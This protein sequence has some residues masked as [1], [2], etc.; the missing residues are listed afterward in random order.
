MDLKHFR[1]V[2]AVAHEKNITKAAEK[3]FIS[4]SSLSYTLS[5]VEKEIGMPLFLRS[6]TGMELT[7]AGEEYYAAAKKIIQI[8]DDL[9]KNLRGK[10]D[11]VRIN[12]AASSVWGTQLFSELIPKFRKQHPGVTFNL[13]QV[14]LFYMEEE[15]KDD[16]LD[17]AFISLSPFEK[18]S[19]NMML[20]RNEA[21]LFAVPCSHPYVKKNPGN[22][23]STKD[24]IE[25]FSQDTF[26]LS[27][28][29]SANRIVAEHLFESIHFQPNRIFEV[30]G[31][32]LTRTIVAKGSDVAFIPI[33]GCDRDS[34]IHYYEMDPPICRYNV[35]LRKPLANYNDIQK[36]FYRFVLAHKF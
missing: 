20:L 27:R 36:A 23:I 26:L 35:L 10:G 29:G 12:I 1:Y 8:Y 22:V 31:L 28:I 17:F 24:L 6:K 16:A 5:T 14:E 13:T 34:N 32:A 25:F 11:N 3:L 7:P 18:L 19:P 15:L 9:Q 30:N 33:S 2:V 4:Q 21:L